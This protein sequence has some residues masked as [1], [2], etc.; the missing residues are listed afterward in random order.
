M[1]TIT[2]LGIGSGLDSEGIINALMSVE[3]RPVSLLVQQTT[4]IKTQLSSIG[5]LQSLAVDDAGSV[6]RLDQRALGHR[7]GDHH[8]RADLGEGQ[9]AGNGQTGGQAARQADG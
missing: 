6:G 9:G 7:A 1:A 8:L 3:R 4:D 2:S 5:Q